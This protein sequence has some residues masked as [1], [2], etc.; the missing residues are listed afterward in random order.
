[1]IDIVCNGDDSQSFRLDDA[2]SEFLN[3]FLAVSPVNKNFVSHCIV[4]MTDGTNS[5]ISIIEWGDIDMIDQSIGKTVKNNGN[6]YTD[7]PIE[8]TVKNNDTPASD[9]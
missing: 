6:P 5:E 9:K 4:A 8:E 3:H 7:G 1:M 2:S